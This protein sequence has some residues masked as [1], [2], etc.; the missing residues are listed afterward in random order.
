[1]AHVAFGDNLHA[2]HFGAQK[3]NIHDAA[4]DVSPKGEYIALGSEDFCLIS[5]TA[6]SQVIQHLNA[7]GVEIEEGPVTRSG[8]AGMLESSY[9]RDPDG[10]LVEISNVIG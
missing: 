7:C 6:V 1:M 5:E 10:N 4:T 8:A 2:V 9:F 3:F